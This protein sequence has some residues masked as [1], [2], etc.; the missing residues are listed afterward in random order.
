MLLF[1]PL[2]SPS[3]RALSITSE[4]CKGHSK[5][6]N[7]K[8]IKAANDQAKSAKQSKLLSEMTSAVVD[9]F[10]IK[11]N[12]RLAAVQDRFRQE[13]IS[14]DTFDKYLEK[15]KNKK[16]TLCHTLVLGPGA[17]T[18]IIE[19]EA[20]VPEKAA[21]DI[22]KL[23]A[24]VD[25][26]FRILPNDSRSMIYSQFD[27]KGIIRISETTSD[28]KKL[29]LT[30]AEEICIDVECEEILTINTD[31]AIQYEFICDPNHLYR[32]SNELR[33]QQLEVEVSEKQF[34]PKMTVKVSTTEYVKVR[35][36]YEILEADERIK[37]VYDNLDD[38]PTNKAR[39]KV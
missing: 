20:E 32:I 28:G 1:R 19:Y 30:Q 35:D 21:K 7:I 17:S 37:G 18:F 3:R 8:G 2:I 38:E 4:L 25:G 6:A 33:D 15:L 13:G 22:K 10:D 26:S 31:G 24:S 23:L 14:M 34:R 5:W 11:K 36:F 9:G 27:E 39:V 12:S 16:S 29:T